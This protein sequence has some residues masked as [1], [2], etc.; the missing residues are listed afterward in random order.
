MSETGT[1]HTDGV[2]EFLNRDY[3]LPVALMTVGLLVIGPKNVQAEPFGSLYLLTLGGF[4]LH[5][6]TPP[7]WRSCVSGP[8]IAASIIMGSAKLIEKLTH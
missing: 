1:K 3:V 2:E 4:L 7:F 5:I 8:L 6:I